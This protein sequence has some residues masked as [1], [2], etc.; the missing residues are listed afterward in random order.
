MDLQR[1]ESMP[2]K[3]TQQEVAEW[4]L[5][6]LVNDL[7]LKP[8]DAVPDQQLKERYRARS[9]DSA[10]IKEG[11]KYAEGHEWLVYEP[12]TQKW[13]LTELGRENA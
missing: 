10:D 8:G 7:K 9:G 12:T 11:L 3:M 2:I 13:H 4:I 6:I 5:D 1:N